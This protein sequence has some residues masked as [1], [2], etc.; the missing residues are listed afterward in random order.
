MRFRLSVCW[1]KRPCARD[2]VCSVLLAPCGC[3]GRRHAVAAL[4]AP[5]HVTCGAGVCKGRILY[6]TSP[7]EESLPQRLSVCGGMAQV[8]MLFDVGASSGCS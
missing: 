1:G 8:V 7:S 5:G 2:D 3:V 4:C 6:I